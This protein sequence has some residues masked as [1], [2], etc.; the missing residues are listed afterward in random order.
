[1]TKT[2]LALIAAL[3]AAPV[4]A[5]EKR[6][7]AVM[8][9]INCDDLASQCIGCSSDDE[10]FSCLENKLIELK[11]TCQLDDQDYVNGL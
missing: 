8:I 10:C 3:V 2:T 4:I 9:T 11:A 5:E 6:E 1:M 7:N